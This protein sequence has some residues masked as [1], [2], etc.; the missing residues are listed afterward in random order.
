MEPELDDQLQHAS[1]QQLIRL[2]QELAAHHPALNT[3][4]AG[5]LKSLPKA[6]GE[7]ETLEE[8]LTEDW[9]FDGVEVPLLHPIAPPLLL[10]LD[11]ASCQ[12]R[13]EGY[14]DRL[15]RGEA[16]RS[17]LEDLRELLDEA[18]K[19]AEHHDYHGAME[20][21]AIVLDER[22]AERH[23]TLMQVFDKAIDEIM[24]ILETL[25]SEAS[26]N[27]LFDASSLSPLLTAEMRQEWLERLFTLWLKRLNTHRL[28]ESVPEIILNVAWSD[29]VALLRSLIQ[30]ELACQP[31]SDH[32]NIVDFKRQYRTRTLEK[33]LK[34]LPRV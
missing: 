15:N 16:F 7:E 11:R 30:K 27:I 24:P 26:S 28:E 23:A 17:L 4:I 12:Q 25:L 9:D 5:F 22:L 31:A 13:I 1:K 18:E 2:L 19:R 34:E 3:E 14:L 20:L 32:S 21:Y 8:D 29:D 6:V 10:P 33:F